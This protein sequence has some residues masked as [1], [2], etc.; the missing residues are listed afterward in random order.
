MP[1]EVDQF[2]T[3]DRLPLSET[4][5]NNELDAWASS[6]AAAALKIVWAMPIGIVSD[7]VRRR[8]ARAEALRIGRKQRQ[9]ARPPVPED[10]PPRTRIVFSEG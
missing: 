4:G 8:I 9:T 6:I 2:S 10:P 3:D 7:E 1:Q 5:Q